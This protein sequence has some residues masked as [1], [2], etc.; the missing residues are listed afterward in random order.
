MA[1]ANLDLVRS[2]VAAWERGDFGSSEWAHPE[3]EI[4]MV[5]GPEP[6]TWMGI[7]GAAEFTRGFLS[8]WNEIRLVADEYRE[9]DDERVVVFVHYSGHGSTSGVDLGQ[10]G[11]EHANLF[12]IRDGKVT[13]YVVYWD[14]D[15]APADLGLTPD[16]GI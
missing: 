8:A 9:V 1:S 2:I 10:M 5:G 4:V 13:A 12:R 6:G 14:L 3:I 16:T 15:S 11:T 7:A